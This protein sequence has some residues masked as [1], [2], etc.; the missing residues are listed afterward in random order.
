MKTT[1]VTSLTIIEPAFCLPIAGPTIASVHTW[2]HGVICLS[3]G[4]PVDAVVWLI[5]GAIINRNSASYKM[6]Q[7][8]T[9]YV[10]ASYNN[11]LI[12]SALKPGDRVTCRVTDGHRRTDS[13]DLIIPSELSFPYM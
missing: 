3:Y 12:T 11:R 10:K 2:P 8:I 4:S 1:T 7:N 6:V 13:K 5:N 9:D